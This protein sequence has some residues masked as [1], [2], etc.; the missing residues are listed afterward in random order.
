MNVA[1]LI[2]VYRDR[3]SLLEL[4]SLRQAYR[5]LHPYELIA[6]KPDSLE[7]ENIRKEFP[8]LSFVSFADCF[9]QGRSGYNKLMLS[10]R[11]YERFLQYDYI[12]IYQL[13]AYVFRDELPAW[14]EKGY[15]YIGAPWLKKRIYHFPV[16]SHIRT[17][18]H[19][20][21]VSRNRLSTQMLYGKVGNGGFS[22]RKVESHYHA[23]IRYEK[24]IEEYLSHENSHFYNE[25]VF[26]A[27][28]VSGFRYPSPM[29]ALAFSF[30]KYPSYCF[31]LTGGRLPF[32]CH[33]WYKRKMRKFW[34]PVIHF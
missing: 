33:A 11:F 31:R 24:K 2:P 28:E 23:A 10:A 29:E 21:K 14:C 9:F 22:L 7:P 4:R 18:W 26:W 16:I 5:L 12:L 17:P 20:Y 8:S 19:Q 6:V 27:T 13:D 32:G 3:L 34:K 15:D 30:D 1:I 25:D